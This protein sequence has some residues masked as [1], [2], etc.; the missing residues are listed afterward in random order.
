MEFISE[1]FF[2]ENII[3]FENEDFG[4]KLFEKGQI[5]MPY[6]GLAELNNFQKKKSKPMAERVN[7]ELP[8]GGCIYYLKR[9]HKHII[10]QNVDIE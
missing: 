4:F 2:L 5:L 6:S 3:I 7:D 9:N 1:G 8:S 10:N